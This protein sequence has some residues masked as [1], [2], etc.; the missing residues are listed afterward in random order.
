MTIRD[1]PYKVISQSKIWIELTSSNL[2]KLQRYQ[3]QLQESRGL[4]ASAGSII[5]ECLHNYL[6]DKV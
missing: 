2:K 5:N 6:A 1:K 3:A 4:K